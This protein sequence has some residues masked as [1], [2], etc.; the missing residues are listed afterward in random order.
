MKVVLLTEEE[1]ALAQRRVSQE[2]HCAEVDVF[3]MQ[4]WERYH[5]AKWFTRARLRK[6]R[7]EATRLKRALDRALTR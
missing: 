5:R 3:L 4:A 7:L 2:L 1:F 6:R